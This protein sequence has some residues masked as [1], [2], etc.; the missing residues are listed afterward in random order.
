MQ[1]RDKLKRTLLIGVFSIIIGGIVGT[2]DAV[3][4]RVLLGITDIRD[5][6]PY[7]FIPFL[8][9]AGIVIVFLYD[10]YGGKS[11]QGMGLL[12]SVGHDKEDSI[13]SCTVCDNWNLVNTFI[14]WECRT[15]RCC[16]TD[17]WNY[18]L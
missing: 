12:F 8:A 10:R 6:H 13:A 11:S 4:G 1:L 9:F 5:A 15:R 3:F 18:F 17:W 2:L 16:S 14:W 7:Y